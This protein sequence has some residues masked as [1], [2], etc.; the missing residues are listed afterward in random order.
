MIDLTGF[1]EIVSARFFTLLAMGA[2]DFILG[3]IMAL[4]QKRFMWAKL[5]GYI[6]SN[7]I[8]ILGWLVAEYLLA[9]PADLVPPG[10]LDGALLAIYTTVFLKL[11]TS[12]LGHLAAMGLLEKAFSKMGVEPTGED[13]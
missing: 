9:L 8:P 6:Q 1:W 12:I 3:V 13:E 11:L 2:L 5:T 10:V 7:G 4:V